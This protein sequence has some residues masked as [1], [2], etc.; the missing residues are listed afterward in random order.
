MKILLLFFECMKQIVREIHTVIQM[1]YWLRISQY[2]RRLNQDLPQ[3]LSRIVQIMTQTCPVLHRS[4]RVM[5]VLKVWK[6]Y[7]INTDLLTQDIISLEMFWP[8][9]ETCSEKVYFLRANVAFTSDCLK[10]NYF[11]NLW[12]WWTFS[13][14][15]IF[16][17]DHKQTILIVFYKTF[18]G[19][20]LYWQITKNSCKNKFS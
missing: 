1:Y 20:F 15:R 13:Y 17:F 11:Y 10:K 18:I 19:Q 12:R 7:V 8:R 6:K 14:G 3:D 4:R 5:T 2:L 16:N 9:I